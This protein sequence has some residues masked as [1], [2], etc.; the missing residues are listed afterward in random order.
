[1]KEE[2]DLILILELIQGNS[3]ALKKIYKFYG[4][5]IFFFINSYTHNKEI[6]EELVQDVFIKLW[7]KREK[8]D[9][10][11]SI[12]NYIYTI[13]K[14]SVIDFIRKNSVKIFSIDSI[15]E[16]E[17]STNNIGEENMLYDE[18]ERLIKEAI[19]RLSLRKREVFELHRIER[20]TYNQIADRLGISVSAVE[21]NISS[22]LKDIRKYLIKKSS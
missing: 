19:E 9:T 13:A 6:T 16:S 5:R 14:H 15:P 18:E 20:L 21:K 22:A 12:K 11:K 3:S 8:L 1:M 4:S 2:L 17:F 10:S 7:N